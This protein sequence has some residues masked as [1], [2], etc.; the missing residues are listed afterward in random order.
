MSVPKRWNQRAHAE[1]IARR[2]GAA[3]KILFD[4]LGAP[5]APPDLA[6]QIAYYLFLD[7]AYG[8]ARQ[9]LE[10]AAVAHPDH[11][12]LLLNL[13]VLQVRTGGLGEARQTLERYLELGGTDSAAYDGLCT[14]CHRLGDDDAARVWGQRAIEE[15]TRAASA[16]APV[17][18][19]GTP[20]ENGRDVISF[21]LWGDHP[22]Y[23]RGALHNAVRAHL[24]YP[25]FTCRFYVD[26]S[27][28]S[29]LVAAL[30]DQGAEVVAEQ[31]EPT[32]RHR[33]TRRFLVADDPTVARYLVRDC[34]SLVNTRE[35]AAV[36]LWMDSGH[37]FHVMRDWWTHTDPMLAGMWGG[38][39]GVLPS[40]APLL[41]SYRSKTMETPNWDQWFLRDCIWPGIRDVTLV[42]DRLFATRGAAP[43]PGIEPPGNLHV[44][45]NE[46]AVRKS[47]QAEELA[48][49]KAS[50]AS[51]QL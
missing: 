28:P 20:R 12:P 36:G 16:T 26:E 38:R 42:H 50:V 44:G 39:G 2:P 45:Q 41:G 22:R 5:D 33:L 51:L 6:L 24:V 31:G 40:L 21:S 7:G 49:F 4:L 11:P 48:R 35:A 47:Q 23:L 29:D 46:Y 27:V 3:L 43:F 18:E 37:A 13:A 25:D 32:N 14:S 17:F 34:D 1:W 10:Q 8:P 9:I 30:E 19:L 15:K